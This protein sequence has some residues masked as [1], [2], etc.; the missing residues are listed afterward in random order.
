M[1]TKYW[2]VYISRRDGYT[3][4]EIARFTSKG[5]MWACLESIKALYANSEY[6]VQWDHDSIA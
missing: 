2:R 6:S 5:V 3:Q 1:K 4:I